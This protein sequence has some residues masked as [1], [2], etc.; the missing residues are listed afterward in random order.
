MTLDPLA[1][2]FK[3]L[4]TTDNAHA[5]DVLLPALDVANESVRAAATAAL[6][7]RR[8]SRGHMEL[9]RRL[10]RLTPEMRTAVAKNSAGLEHG[11][12]QALMHGD[13]E[14]RS[15]AI[16]LVRWLS[17]YSQ[18]PSLLLLLEDKANSLRPTIISL[19]QE[20]VDNLHDH[21]YRDPE[22][23][24]AAPTQIQRDSQRIRD[25]VIG[26]LDQSCARLE[27]HGCDEVVESLLILA[28]VENFAIKK[29]VR[30]LGHPARSA[31]E[32][33][34]LTSTHPGI[35]SKVIDFLGVNFPP[36]KA[37]QAIKER[38][39]PEFVTLLLR[40]LPRRLSQAQ[41]HNF[42]QIDSVAWLEKE[43]LKFDWIPPALQRK[44]VAFIQE[45]GV[46]LNT[47]RRVLDWLVKYGTPDGRQAAVEVLGEDNDV[48]VQEIVVEGL[49]SD[50]ADVQAWA[51]S[52]LRARGIPQAFGLLIER[53]DSPM[54][55]VQEAARAELGDF[56]LKR[57]LDLFDQLPGPTCVQSGK[58]IQKINPESLNDLR[59]E[60][61]S[62]MRSKRIRATRLCL[63]IEVHELMT[64]ALIR[65]LDDED[66]V[67]RRTAIEVLGHIP[68][69]DS[70]A[71][72][73]RMLEDASARVRDQAE[74]SLQQIGRAM[75]AAHG[76]RLMRTS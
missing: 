40:S 67:V 6:V 15:N 18:M 49:Y 12:R 32:R 61:C 11:L 68:R 70:I 7:K 10:H 30:Q 43:R 33:F 54:A 19:V 57:L 34:L 37:V 20:L 27:T 1:I 62:P 65:Q 42:Q 39:D 21:L 59:R 60:M 2:T 17:D 51:T 56:N 38:T 47:K 48:V 14:L 29:V 23:V 13:Q 22:T 50:D 3:Y 72:L 4:A 55:E 26:A 8:S 31:A 63:A 69:S 36:Q 46:Q 44:L 58:L 53:L 71:A 74:L 16:D 41:Q 45:I 35:M 9:I 75:E 73:R 25:Q 52:Q 5:V 24:A 76:D 64:D 66:S 28:D